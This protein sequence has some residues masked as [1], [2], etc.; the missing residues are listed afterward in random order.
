VTFSMKAIGVDFVAPVMIRRAWFCTLSR[1]CWFVFA[2][3]AQVVELYSMAGLTVSWY[4]VL[5][6]CSLAPHVL[7]ASLRMI[8]SFLRALPSTWFMW[9]LHVCLLSKAMPS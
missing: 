9:V 3:V 7:P 8:A 5:S 6:I 2:V 4:I 1:H